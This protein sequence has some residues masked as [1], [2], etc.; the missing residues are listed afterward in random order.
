[1]LDDGRIVEEGT[2]EQ[3]MMLGGWYKE[4]WDHQQLEAS[5]QE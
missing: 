3:L 4:Q 5:L 2:H 1:V